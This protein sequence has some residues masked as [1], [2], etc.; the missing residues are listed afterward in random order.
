MKFV[1][2]IK[3]EWRKSKIQTGFMGTVILLAVLTFLKPGSTDSIFE[4]I[5]VSAVNFSI[6]AVVLILIWW[7]A[8][9]KK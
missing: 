2:E 3:Q 7:F 9:R 1:E 8:L 6:L 5:G 4:F